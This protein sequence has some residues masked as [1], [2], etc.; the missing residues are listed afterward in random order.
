MLTHPS[1]KPFVFLALRLRRAAYGFIGFWFGSVV[2]WRL[3]PF[4]LTLNAQVELK[5]SMDWIFIDDEAVL[6][7]IAIVFLALSKSLMRAHEIEQEN[8]QII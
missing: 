7:A 3:A 4:L 2:I 5:P 6:L 8:K 1:E